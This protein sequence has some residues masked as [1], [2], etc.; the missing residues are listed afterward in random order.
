MTDDR[1]GPPRL[2][3][4]DGRPARDGQRLPVS[5]EGGLPLALPA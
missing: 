1:A 2:R 4:A 3:D 5:G